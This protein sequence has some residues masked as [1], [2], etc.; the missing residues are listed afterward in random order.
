MKQPK[1][2]R[3]FDSLSSQYFLYNNITF[4]NSYK[5]LRMR[6]F[7]ILYSFYIILNT[8]KHLF[9]DKLLKGFYK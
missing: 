3:E 2:Y 8:E 5:I 4:S 9:K 1:G 7:I 6:S